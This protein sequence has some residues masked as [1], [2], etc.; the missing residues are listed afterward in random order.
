MKE[1]VRA[2]AKQQQLG[3]SGLLKR[4]LEMTLSSGAEVHKSDIE[5][6]CRASRTSRLYVRLRPDDQLLLAERAAARG[7]AGAT[8]VSVLVRSHLR[9][10]PPLP[11]A[12][13]VALKRCVAELG[14]IGRNLNQVVRIA[15]ESGRITGP[16]REDLRSMLKVSE[17]LRDHVKGLI[18]ANVESWES[19]HE[20]HGN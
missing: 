12:E 5:Q 15:H 20:S 10:L 19:G 7:M 18:K 17:G 13:L 2:L 4:L 1:R 3:E 16:G 14:A 8:Y 6:T 9:H 11:K